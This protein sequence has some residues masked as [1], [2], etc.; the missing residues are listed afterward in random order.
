[1]N[2]QQLDKTLKRLGISTQVMASRK[3][4]AYKEASILELAETGDDGRE[5]YLIPEAAMAWKQLKEAAK[6]DNE[7]IFIVSAFRSIDR[8]AQL[9]QRKLEKSVKIEDIVRV[10]APP[11]YSEHHSGRALDL[12]TPGVKSASEEFEETSVFQWLDNN[13]GRFHFSLS[14]PRRNDSGYQ[15]EPWHWCYKTT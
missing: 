4:K 11:G 2:T 7:N 6:R 15:Y 8:Q 1:M 5:H 3:L 10:L 9:I 14:Y 12:S 13:A